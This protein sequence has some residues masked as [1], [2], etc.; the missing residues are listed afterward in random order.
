VDFFRG[1]GFID[2]DSPPVV[3]RP[4][5]V[6]SAEK[7]A[8]QRVARISESKADQKSALARLRTGVKL[9][10]MEFD[11]GGGR[12]A[13]AIEK[14]RN[15]YGFR[16][17]GRGTVKDPYVMHDTSQ[18]PSLACVTEDMKAAYYG[19]PHWRSVRES[20]LTIDGCCCVL[21]KDHRDP[22]CHHITYEN[23]FNEQLKDLMT[24]CDECHGRIHAAC[25]LAFPPGIHVTYAAQLGWK[26]PEEWLLP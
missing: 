11:C 8:G 22:R 23:L 21:C 10:K 9:E 17:D 14:L 18:H 25:R 12:V 5:A 7:H 4:D 24:V 15:A 1:Q 13:I 3:V 20:R 26:G 19:T 2:F 6:R 16:I